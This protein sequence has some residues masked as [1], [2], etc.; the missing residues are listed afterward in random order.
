MKAILVPIKGQSTYKGQ[1]YVLEFPK[2]N[3]DAQVLPQ[4]NKVRISGD[5]VWESVFVKVETH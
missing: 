4:T 5:R 3:T 2:T 1:S